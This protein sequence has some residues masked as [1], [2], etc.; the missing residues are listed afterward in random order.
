MTNN[1]T[2]IIAILFVVTTSGLCQTA[3]P[4]TDIYLVNF[5]LVGG[6]F[7][8]GEIQNI[9]QREGYDNQPFFTSEG[10]SLL[11]TSIREDNQADIYRYDIADSSI[12]K[13]TFT[14][15]SEYSP[16]VMPDGK[17]FSVV[18]VEADSTQRLWKFPLAGGEP[19]LVLPDVKPVGYHAWADE[20]TVMLFVLGNPPTLRLADTRT[21][22]AEIIIENIGRSLHK[23][24]KREAISFVHKTSETE[25]HIKQLDL[26]KREA[27]LLT[28]TLSGRE[29]YAW[30]PGGILLMANEAQLYKF[31]PQKDNDWQAIANFASAGLK[32]ITRLAVSPKGNRL[33]FVAN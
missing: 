11:Y 24:P 22:K 5:T 8:F 17:H 20:K 25:W 3:P 13:I 12:S 27:T 18:R 23:T 6:A 7:Q 32:T 29:D 21:G 14:P 26:K 15:E 28:K 16:T 10:Q 19:I 1:R 9:T 33:A 30:A 31:E 4:N 2:R